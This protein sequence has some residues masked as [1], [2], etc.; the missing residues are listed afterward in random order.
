MPS[1]P[2]PAPGTARHGRGELLALLA[3]VPDP[4]D[5]RG[6]RHPLPV[7]L[8]LGL[9]AVLAGARSF[10]VIG[11][12]VAHQ[13][14]QV[15]AGLGVIGAGPAESTIRRAFARVDADVLDQVIGAFMWTRTTVVGARRVIAL[16]GKTVR[17]ARGRR[18]HAPHLVAAFDS[19]Q[20]RR[21][22]RPRAG[23]KS[24]V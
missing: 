6:V 3:S 24:V 21:R 8:V 18:T 16:D 4:R 13:P 17:G 1:S 23:R 15:L 11:E 14:V 2:T 10:V 7:L 12:W 19:W 9:A 5:P 22:N 20:A